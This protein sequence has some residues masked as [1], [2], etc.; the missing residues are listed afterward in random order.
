MDNT[1]NN[2]VQ[3]DEHLEKEKERRKS[4]LK[5]E[6]EKAAEKREK[7]LHK[8]EEAKT[9]MSDVFNELEKKAQEKHKLLEQQ[10]ETRK[11]M[12]NEIL[13]KLPKKEG[14]EEK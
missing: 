13:T 6:I 9:H 1:E 11:S 5:D 3:V 14:S 7:E 4:C 8:K 10:E 12:L 2:N